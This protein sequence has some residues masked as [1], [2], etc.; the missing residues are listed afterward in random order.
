M[1]SRHTATGM[2]HTASLSQGTGCTWKP[3]GPRKAVPEKS[4]S[5]G[6]SPSCRA[7]KYFV[8]ATSMS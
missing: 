1:V 3:A 4:S 6:A 7:S 2:R 5:S 8:E